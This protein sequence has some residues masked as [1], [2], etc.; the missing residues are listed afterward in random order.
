MALKRLY[1]N[2]SK[3]D[4]P[5]I[6]ALSTLRV[7]VSR[8]TY[9]ADWFSMSKAVQDREGNRCLDCGSKDHLHTHHIRR[10]GDRGQNSKANLIAL[11]ESCHSLRH[12]GKD[13]S[14]RR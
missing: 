2:G 1:G 8:Y 7:G 10:L 9:G 4:P 6:R 12:G 3:K 13:V 5:A 14:V 11:C